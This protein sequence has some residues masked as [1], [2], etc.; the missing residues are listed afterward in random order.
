[1]RCHAGP[2]APGPAQPQPVSEALHGT[3][4]ASRRTRPWAADMEPGASPGMRAGSPGLE[5]LSPT[6]GFSLH[7]AALEASAQCNTVISATC[8]LITPERVVS[9]NTNLSLEPFNIFCCV[10]SVC[11]AYEEP[12]SVVLE[13]DVRCA[14]LQVRMQLTDFQQV[15]GCLAI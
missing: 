8:F 7:P 10:P 11:P 9:T 3:P 15:L 6:H 12:L 5:N 13:L 2:G 1:M 4:Q 14:R